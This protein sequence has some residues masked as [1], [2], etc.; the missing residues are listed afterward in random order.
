LL[1]AVLSL[2]SFAGNVAL[3]GTNVFQL[4]WLVSERY[5]GFG[6]SLDETTTRSTK[7]QRLRLL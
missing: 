1:Q 2:A 6:T 3:N 4:L 5:V 7:L